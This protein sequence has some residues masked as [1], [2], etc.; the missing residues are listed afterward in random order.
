LDPSFLFWGGFG[1][2]GLGWVW[3]NSLIWGD[4]FWGLIFGRVWVC[5]F[6][7]L[8]LYFFVVLVLYFF[9][10]LVLYF[11][12]VLVLSFLHIFRSKMRPKLK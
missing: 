10:V 4:L 2:F 3:G 8:V 5:L 6:I 12:V 11:F 7:V 1:V 9:V